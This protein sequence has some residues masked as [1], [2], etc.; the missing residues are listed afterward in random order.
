M[1]RGLLREG[2]GELPFLLRVCCL[3]AQTTPWQGGPSAGLTTGSTRVM[4][5]GRTHRETTTRQPTCRAGQ[6]PRAPPRQSK[7]SRQARLLQVSR[8]A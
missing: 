2:L 6:A 1:G 7:V 8:S 3:S 5:L 4:N